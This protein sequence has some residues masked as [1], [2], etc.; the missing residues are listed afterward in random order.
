MS[1]I[2]AQNRNGSFESTLERLVLFF[3]NIQDALNKEKKLI[4]FFNHP[5]I[6]YDEKKSVL[7][8]IAGK[9]SS[10][11]MLLLMLRVI[12]KRVL[13][14][15][16][17]IINYLE[18]MLDEYKGIQTVTISSAT[19]LSESQKQMLLNRLSDT[20]HKKLLPHFII[21]PDLIAGLKITVNSIILENSIQW[22]L[23]NIKTELDAIAKG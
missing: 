2:Q 13:S 8:T 23:G 7:Q 9:G 4:Y 14:L 22:Q 10:E 18:I 11:S 6:S 5:A 21:Q 17:D 16:P 12:R 3:K 15:L 19:A 1:S 20:I